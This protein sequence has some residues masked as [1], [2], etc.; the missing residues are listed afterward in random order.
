MAATNVNLCECRVSNTRNATA[1]RTKMM[2]TSAPVL[3]AAFGGATN[4]D[5]GDDA[6]EMAVD[7]R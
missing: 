3:V 6:G 1:R 2:R 4:D 5:D 7:G